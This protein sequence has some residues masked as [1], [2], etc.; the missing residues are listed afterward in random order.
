M[1]ERPRI[2]IADDDAQVRTA[3]S[4]LLSPFCDVLGSVDDIR[5]LL[6]D[7]VKLRPD[8]VLL[9]FS[10]PGGLTG[11]EACQR[12]KREAP[13][14]HVV[15]LTGRDEAHLR[16]SA[17]EAGASGFVWKMQAATDLLPTIRSVIDRTAR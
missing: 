16:K 8:V 1:A 4:R 12:L 13:E 14:V 10:L 7:V 15:A 6:D 9:D 2:L 3:V 5:A 17:Y 11:P